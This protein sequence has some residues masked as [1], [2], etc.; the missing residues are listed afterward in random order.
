MAKPIPL[1]SVSA[2]LTQYSYC[3]DTGVFMH[4]FPQRSRRVHKN[5]TA[6][7]LQKNGYLVLY[8]AG[9]RYL[10]HRVAWK[11]IYGCDPERQVDHK[12]TKRSQNFKDNLRLANLEEQAQN[13]SK[14]KNNKS[15]FKGVCWSEANKCWRANIYLAGKQTYLGHYKNPEDAH[16]AYINAAKQHFGEFANAG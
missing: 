11:L 15:G 16:V 12:N 4:K 7:T 8:V 13:S 10:A 1:P 5:G 2:I 6:G 3:S 9:K 14:K